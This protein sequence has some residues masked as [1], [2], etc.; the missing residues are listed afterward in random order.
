MEMLDDIDVQLEDTRVADW[1]TPEVFFLVSFRSWL[2]GYDTTDVNW[3][4][5]AWLG[6]RNMLGLDDTKRTMADLAHFTRVLRA[7]LKR[8]FV[9]LPVCCGQVTVEEYQAMR[10]VRTAQRGELVPASLLVRRL[11]DNDDHLELVDAALALG[12]SLSRAG[13]V[14]TYELRDHSPIRV[15]RALH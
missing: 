5:R 7:T 2:A 15:S 9:Y 6:A 3:W 11:T 13:L 1:P 10:L 14:F 8:T 12:E 4:E